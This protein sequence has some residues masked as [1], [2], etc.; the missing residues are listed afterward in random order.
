[1]L[2]TYILAYNLIRTIMAQ[3]ASK[4]DI[5]PR[6]ISFKGTLQT[7]QAFQPLIDFQEHRGVSFRLELYQQLPRHRNPANRFLRDN[8]NSRVSP[9]RPCVS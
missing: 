2:W 3:S 5:E 8:R 9:C 7:L 6:T 1:M 4:H